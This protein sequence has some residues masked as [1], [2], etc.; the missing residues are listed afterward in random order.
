M[1][2]NLQVAGSI[3][4][5]IV[6]FVIYYGLFPSGLFDFTSGAGLMMIGVK[7][8]PFVLIIA[9]IIFAFRL[10]FRKSKQ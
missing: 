7:L 1:R 4:I 3:L 8:V 5:G 6:V 2:S 10:L 9:A